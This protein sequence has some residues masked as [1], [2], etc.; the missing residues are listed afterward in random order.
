MFLHNERAARR[1]VPLDPPRESHSSVCSCLLFH[2]LDLRIRAGALK[3][4]YVLSFVA[5]KSLA[6]NLLKGASWMSFTLVSCDTNPLKVIKMRASSR[7]ASVI[8]IAQIQ[9]AMILGDEN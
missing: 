4:L 3:H 5:V 2:A 1:L 9:T 6:T 7:D 8:E